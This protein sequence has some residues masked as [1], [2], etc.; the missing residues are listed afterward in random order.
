MI[1]RLI[2]LL[3]IVRCGDSSDEPLDCSEGLIN[4]DRECTLVFDEG[5]SN[6]DDVCICDDGYYSDNGKCYDIECVCDEG[7]FI[8]G[9]E[10]RFSNIETRVQ[11]N[12]DISKKY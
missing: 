8:N 9:N 6:K 5:S 11:K 12:I 3:L 4:I 1:R 10:N 7:Y 2:I